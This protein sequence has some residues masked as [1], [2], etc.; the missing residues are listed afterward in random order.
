MLGSNHIYSVPG[1]R[2]TGAVK[3]VF[4]YLAV[5]YGQVNTELFTVNTRTP[6][7]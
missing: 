1:S 6:V 5:Y 7:L 3:G 2:L 4:R